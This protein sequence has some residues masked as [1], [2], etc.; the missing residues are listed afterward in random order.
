MDNP[1]SKNALHAQREFHSPSG[2]LG[3][4][5]YRQSVVKSK[6]AQFFPSFN[7]IHLRLGTLRT[8]ADLT[9]QSAGATHQLQGHITIKVL[10]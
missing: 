10:N 9:L 2:T 8:R 4:F 7:F 5:I 1:K 3:L 6:F